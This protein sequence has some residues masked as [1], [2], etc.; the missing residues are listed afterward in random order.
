MKTILATVATAMLLAAPAQA[1]SFSFAGNFTR[2]DDVQRFD[3][4]VGAL[5]TITLR[6]YSYAGGTQ[7]DDT[8][9]SA[10]GFDPILALF[11]ASTGALIEQQDDANS[12]VPADPVTGNE[13]D[14]NLDIELAA[15][16]YFVTV[17]QYN[18][19]ANGPLFSDGFERDGEGNFTGPEFECSNGIFCDV[20]GNN[21]TSAWNFDIL[22]VDS[23]SQ[24]PNPPA[25]PLPASGLLLLGA[26]A[27]VA[28][29]R[30]RAARN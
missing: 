27:G 7:A 24:E 17:M 19:F 23:A 22:N 21:R 10:G 6:S 18:N 13:Y 15:G 5:S 8:I 26:M 16:N 1:A 4:T 25:V 11:D 29:L 12:G 14:V 30:R 3:F 2:D 28:A 9:V 20:G